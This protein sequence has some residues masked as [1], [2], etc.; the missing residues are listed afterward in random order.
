MQKELLAEAEKIA[1]NGLIPVIQKLEYGKNGKKKCVKSMKY[2]ELKSPAEALKHAKRYLHMNKDANAL[3]VLMQDGLVNIDFDS[4]EEHQQYLKMGL[5]QSPDQEDTMITHTASGKYHYIYKLPQHWLGQFCKTVHTEG[6]NVDVLFGENTVE[7]IYPTTLPDG[8]KYQKGK[9]AVAKEMPVE[10]R[11]YLEARLSRGEGKSSKPRES[12]DREIDTSPL[13]PLEARLIN[14][15]VKF[16]YRDPVL[17][18]RCPAGFDFTYDHSLPDP[19]DHVR[20]HDQIDN[21]VIINE[22]ANV[23]IVG[24]YSMMCAKTNAV[25]CTLYEPDECLLDD[26]VTVTDPATRVIEYTDKYVHPFTDHYEGRAVRI[27]VIE[28]DLGTGKTHQVKAHME[29]HKPDNILILTPRI[30]FGQCLQANLDGFELYCDHTAGNKKQ[31][32]LPRLICQME[33][34][35]RISSAMVYDHIYIDEIESCLKQFSSLGTMKKRKECS[36]MFSRLLRGAKRIVM[37]DAHISNRTFRV[38]A[39]LGFVPECILMERN[40]F[41]ARER[42]AIELREKEHLLTHLKQCIEKRLPVCFF[43]SSR[44]FLKAVELICYRFLRP[45]EYVIYTPEA[46]EAKNRL[47]NVEEEWKD[48]LVVAYNTTITVG[49]DFNL[50]DVFHTVLVYAMNFGCCPV[51][52]I[53]Q[54]IHRVRK[55]KS[56][57]IYYY[58]SGAS[59]QD[60]APDT[61]KLAVKHV[62]R[63]YEINHLIL[64]ESV[65]DDTH[66][67]APLWLYNLHVANV[68]EDGIS[69]RHYRKVFDQYLLRCGYTRKVCGNSLDD[70]EEIEE[71]E[72]ELD[73]DAIPEITREEYEDHEALVYSRTATRDQQLAF[74]K[75][76]Y[77]YELGF[78]NK[79]NFR[80]MFNNIG[81]VWLKNVKNENCA[82]PNQLLNDNDY[83]DITG[84]EAIQLKNVKAI[85]DKLGL[86]S[87]FEKKELLQSVFDTESLEPYI[88]EC[89]EI[90]KVKKTKK[91]MTQVNQ[92]IKNWN[93]NQF[94]FVEGK[95]KGAKS[96][97]VDGKKVKIVKLV[98]YD[99][100]W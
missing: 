80:L 88:N 17:V 5:I 32:Y 12:Y 14:E 20:I 38:L 90:L 51:R 36:E 44:K 45:D 27:S 9:V 65:P 26:I 91:T 81:R 2:R 50:P 62:Q 79:N 85:I 40:K 54:A 89:H 70:I 83:L 13:S 7:Y 68:L 46:V 16:G 25:L 94:E 21:Y 30:L 82:E 92:I 63:L 74:Y 59:D 55:I 58:L 71:V 73:Y 61:E 23:A 3:G 41:V 28:S 97:R 67:T 31:L 29:K 93:G 11:E 6:S 66:T 57:R 98:G 43:S 39:E 75:Y 69:K 37:C 52:D 49:V 64:E 42:L 22:E 72:D 53:F 87:S 18:R 100:Y 19:L 35:H 76:Q 77:Q 34:L 48:K 56:N 33:S 10:L 24:T 15:L 8:K 47:R 60:D 99:Y 95:G 4:L 1:R 96:T 78:S 84:I 86:K